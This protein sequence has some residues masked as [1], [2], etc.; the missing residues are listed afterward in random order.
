[1]TLKTQIQGCN[2]LK[3]LGDLIS[4]EGLGNLTC[5]VGRF[6][7]RYFKKQDPNYKGY[8][9]LNDIMRRFEIL[10]K[11]EQDNKPE[12]IR[13]LGAVH[14]M[15]KEGKAALSRVSC[16]RRFLTT[17]KQKLGNRGYDRWQQGD[18]ILEQYEGEEKAKLEIQEKNKKE[19]ELKEKEIKTKV[20]EEFSPSI[21]IV[22]SPQ[23]HA[24]GGMNVGKMSRDKVAEAY[25]KKAEDDKAKLAKEKEAKKAAAEEERK[26]RQQQA[27]EQSKIDAE[28]KAEEAKRASEKKLSDETKLKDLES[29]KTRLSTLSLTDL[30]KAYPMSNG[31]RQSDDL[32]PSTRARSLFISDLIKIKVNA[33]LQRKLVDISVALPDSDEEDIDALSQIKE[34]PPEKIRE[35]A[36]FIAEHSK[37]PIQITCQLIHRMCTPD[38]WNKMS[39]EL[40]EKLS[41][42][43]EM[44]GFDINNSFIV[45]RDFK[46]RQKL[47]IPVQSVR[48]KWWELF[49]NRSIKVPGDPNASLAVV[50]EALHLTLYRKGEDV[51]KQIASQLKQE[52]PGEHRIIGMEFSLEYYAYIPYLRKFYEVF[53]PKLKEIPGLAVLDL[54]SSDASDLEAYD[55]NQAAIKAAKR[56]LALESLGFQISPVTF[57]S[58]PS[59]D[60]RLAAKD[61]ENLAKNVIDIV[62]AQPGLVKLDC[63]LKGVK[64]PDYLAAVM[65]VNKRKQEIVTEKKP[66]WIYHV[67]G[68]LT[69]QIT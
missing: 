35:I 64:N 31:V 1:M 14:E 57:T 56:Q 30:I 47:G 10:Y 21:V 41:I 39:K 24:L 27:L 55:K 37:H 22:G 61:V 34:E 3:A 13:V 54:G 68:K 9:N 43:I 45:H 48:V 67:I 36:L 8:V 40:A 12:I 63:Q 62:N 23:G 33:L 15:D 32:F 2:T 11:R 28:K 51:L 20:E 7:G 59:P 6:G 16:L 50:S 18:Q 49:S 44:R 38:L 5:E 26:R 66:Y 25:R 60:S 4:P 42:Q 65:M 19:K 17:I 46:S 58:E 53:L 52:E 29:E 69:N